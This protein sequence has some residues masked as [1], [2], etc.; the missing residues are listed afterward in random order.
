MASLLHIEE[1]ASPDNETQPG[2]QWNAFL[3]LGFRPL[4]LAGCLWAMVSMAV[5][6]FGQTAPG[7]LSGV[8]WHAH[9]ML[10]GFVATIAVGFLLTATSNWTGRNPLQGPALG[11]L[12]LLWFAARVAW[13]LPSDAAF[14]VALICELFF[15]GWATAALGRVIF[16]TR[17]R[18]NYAVPVL[19]LAMG[20]ADGLFIYGTTRAAPP[21]VLG[22]FNTGLLC[23]AVIALLVAGRVMPFFAMR[24]LPGLQLPALQV[25]GRIQ[26]VACALAL[27]FGL[28][29]LDSLSG[30]A[31]AIAASIS[32]LQLI[33]WQFWQVRKVP[34]LWVLY[35]AYAM[36]SLGLFLAAARAFGVSMRLAWP[37]HVIGIGGFALMIIGMVTRT[38]LG[39]LGRP[40]QT[41][42]AMVVA[43]VL[44]MVSAVLRL[45]V[46]PNW[47]NEASALSQFLLQTSAVAWIGAFGIF[48]WKFL[49]MLIRPRLAPSAAATPVN[50]VERK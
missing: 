2:G 46:L 14:V 37:A 15:F 33:R 48:V 3:E 5:W 10:W 12:V 24:A 41:D 34:L 4:Y 31:L 39:H 27:L 18:R 9:E 19:V 22:Y 23:M 45:A 38:S 49:P 21:V 17:N 25:P 42:R 11:A 47:L 32:L 35:V 6:V 40:L 28:V 26:L 13:L 8:Y 16:A 1:P 43:F 20:L 30:L 29:Q 36:L 7:R 44:V 50:F